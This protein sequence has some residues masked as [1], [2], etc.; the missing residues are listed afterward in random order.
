MPNQFSWYRMFRRIGLA[1][2]VILRIILL[3]LVIIKRFLDLG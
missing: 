1:T 2:L 3:F